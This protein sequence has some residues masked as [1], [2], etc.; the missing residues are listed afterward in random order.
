MTE[1]APAPDVIGSAEVRR[2][3]GG[4][5]R[6]RLRQIVA[7][8]DSNGFP[9]WR[10]VPGSGY[11]GSNRVWDRA[12]VRAWQTARTEPRRKAMYVL[13]MTHGRTGSVITAA[14]AAGVSTTTG[15][16]WLREVGRLPAANPR[17]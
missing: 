7:N 3:L 1:R 17:A 15:Y 14:R 11:A 13:L 4:I 12:A 9:H 16:K 10:D 5:S 8:A 6:E 2:I